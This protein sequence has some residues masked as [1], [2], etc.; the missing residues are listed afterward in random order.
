MNNKKLSM[1]TTRA[2]L[3]TVSL[4][5]LLAAVAFPILAFA[6]SAFT[7]AAPLTNINAGSS[8]GSVYV[9]GLTNVLGC[10]NGSMVHFAPATSDSAK[11]LAL[12][13]AAFLSGKKLNC[14]VNA[15]D[16][17]GMQV[18]VQCYLTN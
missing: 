5:T 12:A 7:G 10:S 2:R 16:S 18:G 11:V 8:D 13:T 4:C 9:S 6:T 1:P 15:C 17:N 3:V 14:M